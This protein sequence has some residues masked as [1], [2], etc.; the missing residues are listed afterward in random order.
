MLDPLVKVTDSRTVTGFDSR[1]LLPKQVTQWTFT[2]GEHGP[3]IRTTPDA[4]FTPEY[5]E[6]ET[7]KVVNTLRATG[8]I[9]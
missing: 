4:D 8:A 3:F 6:A 1:T 7:Q 2:I 9:K 5:V